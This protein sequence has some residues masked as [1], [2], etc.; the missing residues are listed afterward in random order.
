MAKIISFGE[1]MKE[2]LSSKKSLQNGVRTA[3]IDTIWKEIFG[4]AAQYTD[5]LQIVGSTLFITSSVG[6]FKNELHYQ[7][8]LIIQR[9]NEAFGEAVIDKVVIN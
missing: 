2:V 9:V 1:A 8:H 4:S 6:A 3:Q 5:K 7:R